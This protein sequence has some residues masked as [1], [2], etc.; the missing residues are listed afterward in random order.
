M[1]KFEPNDVEQK[2]IE[3]FCIVHKGCVTI[4]AMGMKFT[5]HVTP[6]GIGTAIEIECNK[7]GKK[8]N[9]TDFDSW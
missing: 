9:I 7:C 6:G 2:R 5:Y 4:D 8:K 1:F 3:E